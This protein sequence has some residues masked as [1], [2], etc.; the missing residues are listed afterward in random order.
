MIPDEWS[1]LRGEWSKQTLLFLD[2]LARPGALICKEEI[3]KKQLLCK[4]LDTVLEVVLAFG[5]SHAD[6]SSKDGF[7]GLAKTLVHSL[8]VQVK[9]GD[10]AMLLP[11]VG[12]LLEITVNVALKPLH[13][14]AVDVLVGLLVHAQ[15][16]Q[17]PTA[18]SSAPLITDLVKQTSLGADLKQFKKQWTSVEVEF[19]DKMDRL[20]M[21]QRKGDHHF[22]EWLVSAIATRVPSNQDRFEHFL[23]ALDRF[24]QLAFAVR[25]S[26]VA[27]D[28]E[29]SQSI[30]SVNPSATDDEDQAFILSQLIQF[31]AL[32][33]RRQIFIK[34]VHQLVNIHLAHGNLVEAAYA[35]KLHADIYEWNVKGTVEPI[36]KDISLAALVDTIHMAALEANGQDS[37]QAQVKSSKKAPTIK[38]VLLSGL[39]HLED[40]DL[41][42]TLQLEAD[43]RE[44]MY[45]L[46]IQFLFTAH[47][48]EPAIAACKELAA[49]YENIFY[50]FERLAKLQR[51]M[52]D[53]YE[54]IV[55]VDRFYP[56]YYRVAFL[57]KGWIEKDSRQAVSVR[58]RHLIYRGKEWEKLGEFMERILT[59]Y[60]GAKLVKNNSWP[61][62]ATI[63]ESDEKWLQICKVDV[64]PVAV[65]RAAMMSVP[66]RILQWSLVNGSRAFTFSRPLKKNIGKRGASNEFACLWLEQFEMTTENPLP[67]FLKCSE[68]KQITRREIS[69]IENAVNNVE[70]KNV[71]LCS[72][73]RKYLPY[74]VLDE[75]PVLPPSSSKYR[76]SNR[77]ST[78]SSKRSSG[79]YGGGIAAGVGS[80]VGGDHHH[81]H[82]HRPY[83]TE[84][85]KSGPQSHLGAASMNLNP[86][87]MCLNGAVDAP[88]NGGI[89]MYRQ[90]F[91]ATDYALENPG[92]AHAVHRLRTAI[93]EQVCRLR[94]RRRHRG[95]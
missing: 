65:D 63:T 50:D 47:L 44:L 53:L 34:Y 55:V 56:E 28:Q 91:L 69:P 87:T 31:S 94:R 78:N 15:P 26:V 39:L 59:K 72:L 73:E 29:V 68:V 76:A 10:I 80:G 38:E 40:C 43:R 25:D 92:D 21:S 52:A 7:I 41:L 81:H 84:K 46:L 42:S 64:Q 49:A 11:C 74:V 45:L 19:I 48:Y 89:P 27:E 8:W 66:D 22:R 4:I 77:M 85:R 79:P 75:G 82:H 83:S 14:Q 18:S 16:Q 51:F 23:L 93:H 2:A 57:G 13:D 90:S 24:L 1:F 62:E 71:E 5:E 86:L 20:V 36:D 30:A 6:G 12:H 95:Y 3:N 17:D 32:L 9:T 35:L 67:H 33:N 61:V 70:S 37:T 60:P 58:G 88:V 54:N